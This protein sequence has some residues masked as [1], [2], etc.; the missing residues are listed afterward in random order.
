MHRR[1]PQSH[2]AEP[3]RKLR[4]RAGRLLRQGEA[5][6]ALLA[7]REAAALEPSGPSF[8]RVA[9]LL[10][11]LGKHGDAVA[12]LKQ[13]LYCFRHD[14]QR[15]RARTVARMILQ[16]DPADAAARKRAA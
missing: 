9:H 11:Q 16:L 14:E 10:T 4:N 15:G 3:V 1:F 7:L 2:H 13:A 8:V 5:R 6:K 12:A